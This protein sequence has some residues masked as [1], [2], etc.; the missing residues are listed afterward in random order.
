M[1][2]KL[3]VKVVIAES[4][5]KSHPTALETVGV[6][7][8]LMGRGQARCGGCPRLEAVLVGIQSRAGAATGGA[9]PTEA[10]CRV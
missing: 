2:G 10:V 4:T 7:P 6:F 3:L 5:L 1:L 9:E 8:L